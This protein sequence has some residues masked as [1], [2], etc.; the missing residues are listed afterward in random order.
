MGRALNKYYLAY[1]SAISALALLI[2]S[3]EYE[4]VEKYYVSIEKP[5]EGVPLIVDLSLSVDTV[6]L[7]QGSEVSLRIDPG[8][9]KVHS[10]QYF[11]DGN[12]ISVRYS[13]PKYFTVLNFAL[14][15]I[16]K[17]RVI[18]TTNTGSH[19]IADMVG[20][21]VFQYTSKE[22]TLVIKNYNTFSNMSYR[23][24]NNS[25]FFTWKEYKSFDFKCYRLIELATMNSYE[26]Y[27][28]SFNLSTWAGEGG[29]YDL[30]V[31]DNDTT[32]FLWGR[33][34]VNRSLPI[35]RIGNVNNQIALI[36]NKTIWSD[37][38]AEYQ[39]F[40]SFPG[41]GWTYLATLGT[42]DTSF[43]IKSN[44]NVFGESV[45]F[46]LYSVPKNYTSLEN[47]SVFN[48]YLDAVSALP[49]PV[50]GANYYG[51]SCDGFY[52]DRFSPVLNGSVLYRYSS[53]TD[54]VDSL[55][56][57]K[58]WWKFS[59]GSRF[60]LFSRD[61]VM[62][63]FDLGT[64]TI[65][66]SK[67]FKSF[68]GN[69]YPWTGM[70]I[71]D[72]GICIFTVDNFVY[73]YDFIQDKLITSE[74]INSSAFRISPDGH[75]FT[76]GVA[77]SLLIYRINENSVDLVTGAIFS[78]GVYLYSNYG[79]CAD[80]TDNLYFF[81]SPVL[82]IRSCLDLSVTRSIDIGDYF[83]NIDFCSG[84]IL[85]ARSGGDCEIH[86]FNSGELLQKIKFRLP[87]GCSDCIVL[88]GNIIYA[89]GYKF[90]LND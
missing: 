2:T 85:S 87:S 31:K 83:N 41:S 23:V 5:A 72:N 17:F 28:T 65:S 50:Y 6:S 59:P 35:L 81:E 10:V 71:S 24:D 55:M 84:K 19:S 58:F 42:S 52:F 63:L 27:D 73:V 13:Y 54:K 8:N 61:S 37:N 49:G 67:N 22:W 20:S 48:S 66:R 14:P 12:E 62:N 69:F 82:Y 43:L 26:I 90:L 74:Y 40:Q 1:I 7:Y 57:Y 76:A 18:I 15:G 86:D 4:P 36:W 11:L 44:E 68:A 88:T 89:P 32:E 3:C 30:Y 39:L 56:D 53:A 21:E 51:P 33:C 75:Y 60:L 38:I 34:S 70:D 47:N 78:N 29:S 16:H 80:G 25:L 46:Y 9:L 64:N 45:S 77:D 79:F